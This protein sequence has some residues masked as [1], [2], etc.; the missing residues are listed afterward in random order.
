MLIH[1]NVVRSLRLVTKSDAAQHAGYGSAMSGIYID[2]GT[3]ECVATDGRI[4][5]RSE[6]PSLDKASDFPVRINGNDEIDPSADITGVIDASALLTAA[7]ATPRKAAD[8]L[9]N[10]AVTSPT[11][12]VTTDLEHATTNNGRDLHAE[13]FP[14]WENVIKVPDTASTLASFTLNADLL[15]TIAKVAK[16]QGADKSDSCV[17]FRIIEHQENNGIYFVIRDSGDS[18]KIDGVV[19]P[20][21]LK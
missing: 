5:L 9:A 14:A 10:V 13:T 1:R 16:L 19:M 20:M 18:P 2:P 17:T 6:S 4:L 15:A 21:R 8:V 3:R 7:K 12:F 11:T